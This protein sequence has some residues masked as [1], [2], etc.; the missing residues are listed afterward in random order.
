MYLNLA[1]SKVNIKVFSVVLNVRVDKATP[2]DAKGPLV[3]RSESEPTAYWSSACL[4]T[5]EPAWEAAMH[6]LV[7]A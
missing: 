1:E 4:T 5:C 3:H 7:A 2:P 6:Y